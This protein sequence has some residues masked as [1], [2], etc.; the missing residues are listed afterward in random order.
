MLYESHD[1]QGHLYDFYPVIWSIIRATSMQF[2]K[3][4]GADTQRLLADLRKRGQPSL[5]LALERYLQ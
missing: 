3:G 1:E 5:C 2:E 4:S